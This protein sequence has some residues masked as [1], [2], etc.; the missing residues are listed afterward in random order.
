MKKYIHEIPYKENLVQ[1]WCNT[2]K[3]QDDPDYF[4]REYKCYNPVEDYYYDDPIDLINS[5]RI[6]RGL[7]PYYYEPSNI[8]VDQQIELTEY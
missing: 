6:R 5:E 8:P 3:D 1:R 4:K 7:E 2:I